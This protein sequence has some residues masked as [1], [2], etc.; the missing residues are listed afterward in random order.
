MKK[1]LSIVLALLMMFSFV[2]CVKRI[3]KDENGNVVVPEPTPI[4]PEKTYEELTLEEKMEIAA[5]EEN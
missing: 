2:G 4:E 5:A 1:I 3:E